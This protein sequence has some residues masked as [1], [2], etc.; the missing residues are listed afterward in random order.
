MLSIL[1]IHFPSEVRCHVHYEDDTIFTG[2]NLNEMIARI[3][4]DF[5]WARHFGADIILDATG[6]VIM[7]I[8]HNHAAFDALQEVW[9]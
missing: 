7:T 3:E 1:D 8:T 9:R 2:K 6:E 5:L 4:N